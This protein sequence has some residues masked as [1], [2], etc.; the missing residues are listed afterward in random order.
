[1]RNSWHCAQHRPGQSKATAT[2]TAQTWTRDCC[3]A[4]PP[5]GASVEKDTLAS[6]YSARL[7]A[8]ANRQLFV[9]GMLLEAAREVE[10]VEPRMPSGEAPSRLF[11]GPAG[12]T[13]TLSSSHVSARPLDAFTISKG[14]HLTRAT[15]AA[16]PEPKSAPSRLVSALDC[17]SAVFALE[18]RSA[19]LSRANC[20]HP[21]HAPSHHL[22][23]ARS[24]YQRLLSVPS[25]IKRD[26][27]FS[28]RIARAEEP[29]AGAH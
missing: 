7:Y 15:V 21:R 8:A 5:S 1:M 4:F 20:V 17:V 24:S 12:A 25:I 9:N 27:G 2:R 26:H 6:L 28:T 23:A 13:I 14:L 10:K 19:L 18:F 3:R 16:S 11:A 29:A 22:R